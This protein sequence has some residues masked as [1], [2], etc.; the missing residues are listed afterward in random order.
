M[1]EYSVA[2]KFSPNWDFLCRLRD[3][4]REVTA[5]WLEENYDAIG[6]RSTVDLKQEFQ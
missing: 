1:R 6:K 4:G 5:A 3:A 2:S